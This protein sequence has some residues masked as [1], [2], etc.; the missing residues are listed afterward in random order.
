MNENTKVIFNIHGARPEA[1]A[2]A[3]LSQ[4][5][6]GAA[7]PGWPEVAEALKW[8]FIGTITGVILFFVGLLV[9]ANFIGLGVILM[10][11]IPL[12]AGPVLFVWGFCNLFKLLRPAHKTKSSKAFQ[13]AWM[14]S[15]LGEDASGSRFGKPAYAMSTM[16]RLLPKDIAFNTAMFENYLECLHEAMSQAADETAKTYLDNGWNQS[17]PNK[18]FTITSERDLSPNLR[19]V[20]AVITYND[21]VSRS[22]G[23]NNTE[24]AVSAVIELHV[25][26]YYIRSGR[27]WFPYDITP[28]FERQS[29]ILVPETLSLADAA[30]PALACASR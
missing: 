9:S 27:Y 28:P 8:F 13:W 15:V 5:R 4:L 17:G 3:R 20:K 6:F 10:G 29:N 18:S 26:Q 2:A 21:C 30:R 23:N 11:Y 16:R 24:N 14:T 7:L 25:T 12:L 19:E 1:S 22:T